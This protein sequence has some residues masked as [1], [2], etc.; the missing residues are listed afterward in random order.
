MIFILKQTR[1]E[2]D[3]L[4]DQNDESVEKVE[5]RTSQISKAVPILLLGTAVAAVFADPLVDA[6]DNFSTATSIPSFFVSF[7]ILPFA[8][9]SE[10]VSTMIFVSKKKLRTSSL[11]YSE[12]KFLESLPSAYASF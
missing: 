12:V 11:A 7:I 6:V 5:N 8:S 2:E 10:I 4:E 9:S 1:R 3:L